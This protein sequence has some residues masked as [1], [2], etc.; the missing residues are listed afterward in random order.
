M[1][2]S[3]DIFV[4][5]LIRIAG[6]LIIKLKLK[7]NKALDENSTLSY[8]A[9]PA[10]WDHTVLLAKLPPDTSERAPRPRLNP[11]Q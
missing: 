6:R 7:P 3:D 10:M 11:S 1:L 9:S 8:G 4:G 5:C 2:I